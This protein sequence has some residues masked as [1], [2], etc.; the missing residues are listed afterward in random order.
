[1]GIFKYVSYRPCGG[2]KEFWSFFSV[3]RKPNGGKGATERISKFLSGTSLETLN[4]KIKKIL[5]T[6][7]EKNLRELV[8]V[9]WRY[10]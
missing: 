10:Y 5:W 9:L 6:F 4:I 7:K 8:E 2:G 1:L 3:F